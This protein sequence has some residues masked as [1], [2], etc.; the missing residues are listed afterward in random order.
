M[1]ITHLELAGRRYPMV[2][3]LAATEAM[4][5]RFGSLEAMSEELHCD[6]VK[7]VAQAVDGVLT[8]LMDA[9]RIYCEAVGMEVPPRLKCRPADLIDPTD[10]STMAIIYSAMERDSRREVEVAGKNVEATPE[11]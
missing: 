8:I 9:G 7:R 5:E 10:P 11:L 4:E 6:S 1:K 3:S 2:F